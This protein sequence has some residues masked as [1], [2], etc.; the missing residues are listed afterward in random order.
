MK[1]RLLNDLGLTDFNSITDE[2]L[3]EV[4]RDETAFLYKFDSSDDPDIL[5]A[6]PARSRAYAA[7]WLAGQDVRSLCSTATLYRHGRVLAEYGLDIFSPR[8]IKN[9][10]TRVRVIDLKPIAAPEW[11]DWHEPKKDAA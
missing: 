6:I 2:K 10:P 4:Y 11:Y 8:N 3:A 9:F 7:A 5:A 1:R